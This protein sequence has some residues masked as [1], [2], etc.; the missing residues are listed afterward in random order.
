MTVQEYI[1]YVSS[2]ETDKNKVM[3]IERIYKA[4]LP[5]KVQLIISNN[6]ETV[7][8]DNG[9]RILSFSE[10]VNAEEE[11][12]VDFKK[13]GIIPLFDC[14]DNDFIVYHYNEDIWSKFNIIDE[15]SFKNKDDFIEL[16]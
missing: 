4:V 3:S 7:F 2:K 8:F 14:K 9:I 11:L 6:D 15:V 16:L 5:E 13:Y 10:V 12:H 1:K